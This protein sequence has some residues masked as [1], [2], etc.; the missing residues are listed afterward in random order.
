MQEKKEEDLRQ[1]LNKVYEVGMDEV[2]RGSIFGPVFSAVVV[3]TEKNK[4]TLKKFGVMDSKK[5]TS[6]KK[7]TF[8]SQKFYHFLQIMELDNPL[9]EK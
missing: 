5:L 9:L 2:G 7:E 3:L 4:F 1:V 8:F 6:E